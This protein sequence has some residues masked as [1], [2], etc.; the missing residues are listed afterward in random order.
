MTLNRWTLLLLAPAL[1]APLLAAEP[2]APVA[3]CGYISAA[4]KPPQSEDLYP[5][6]IRRI[7]G[8]DT[9]KRPAN[10]Y[11]LSAGTHAIAVQEKIGSTP[12]GYTKLRKLGNREVALVYKIIKIEVQANTSYQIGAQLYPDK[13][14]PKQPNAYWDPVVWRTQPADCP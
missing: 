5:A 1:A 4:A 9:P 14:D 12:R 13:L 6:E 3:G 10:R 11:R 7:D 8:A 2:T